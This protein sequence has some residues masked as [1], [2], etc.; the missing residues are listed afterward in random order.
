MNFKI[1]I[2][3]IFKDLK[4]DMNKSLNKDLENTHTVY[5]DNK[6]NA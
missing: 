4:K 2:L 1:V 6:N 3:Y 5:W